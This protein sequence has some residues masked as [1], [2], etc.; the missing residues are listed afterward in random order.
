MYFSVGLRI[1][2]LWLLKG[3]TLIGTVDEF[4]NTSFFV[5]LCRKPLYARTLVPIVEGDF[6][7]NFSHKCI[8]SLDYYI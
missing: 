2:L 6:F 5:Y 7:V 8:N 1:S 3:T 4:V